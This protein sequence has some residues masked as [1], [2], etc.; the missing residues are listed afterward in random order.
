MLFRSKVLPWLPALAWLRYNKSI[1]EFYKKK[2]DNAIVINISDFNKS[3]ERSRKVLSD[4]LNYDLDKPY[5]DVFHQNEIASKPSKKG[6]L[7]YRILDTYYR[8][9]LN[10]L[11]NQL[12]SIATVNNKNN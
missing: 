10:T 2:P 5:T 6:N 9:K 11:Y 4:F 12:E 8:N 1:I 7:I 3:H